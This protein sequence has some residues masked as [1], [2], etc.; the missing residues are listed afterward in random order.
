[1]LRPF[2]RLG[3]IRGLRYYSLQNPATTCEKIS[4]PTQHL[5]TPNLV[6]YP[7]YIPRNSRGSLPVYSDI[8]NNG[9]RILV[10]IRNI[11]GSVEKF[12]KDVKQALLDKGASNAGR[13]KVV[14]RPRQLVL[15]GGYWKNDVME[16]LIAKGF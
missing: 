14:V 16:W 2:K 10:L 1:M 5:P 6:R 7:Y 15:Q 12:A 8:R 3:L 11:E 9:T 4:H 13:L